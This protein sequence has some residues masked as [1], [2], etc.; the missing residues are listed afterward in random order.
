MLI[1]TFFPAAA[2]SSY[3]DRIDV[4]DDVKN[5]IAECLDDQEPVAGAEEFALSGYDLNSVSKVY[6]FHFTDYVESWDVS[7]TISSDDYC[8][9]VSFDNG[10]G[11][12]EMFFLEEKGGKLIFNGNSIYTNYEARSQYTN[13][14][15]YH[16][17]INEL[18]DGFG[19]IS[20]LMLCSDG[21]ECINFVYFKSEGKEYIIPYSY[22]ADS[23]NLYSVMPCN[24]V[25]SKEQFDDI[26]REAA[27]N[28]P[29]KGSTG[30][31]FLEFDTDTSVK[32]G[33]EKEGHPM[34]FFLAGGTLFWI[35]LT[36]KKREKMI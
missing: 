32:T 31:S 36:D 23:R 5:K 17:E 33:Y 24:K 6:S 9:I 35:V 30:G 10:K 2:V 27:Q 22:R 12:G 15:F 20:D 1:S 14:N 8:Y 34:L 25:Y 18:L 11:K 13:M 29:E 4:G 26:I 3:S 7:K 21:F 28:I 19:E 16:K